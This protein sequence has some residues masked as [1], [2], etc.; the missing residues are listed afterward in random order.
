MPHLT[1]RLLTGT[2]L[3]AALLAGSVV[4]PGV[5]QAA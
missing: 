2:L 1:R 4:A 3:I 5:A